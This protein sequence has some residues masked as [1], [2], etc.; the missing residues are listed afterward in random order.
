MVKWVVLAILLLPLAEIGVFILVAA[1][2]GWLWAFTLLLATTLA[3]VL[4]LRWAGRGR[5]ARFRVAVADGDVTAFE[6]S[7]GGFL[8]VLAGLLLLLPGFITDLI[9]ALLLIGPVQRRCAAA[10]RRAV[11]G[12]GNRRDHVVDLTPGEWTQVPDREL[13]QRRGPDRPG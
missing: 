8:T 10:F 2:L 12:G 1:L 7:T 11:V 3:G 13:D 5:L 6:A 9:G 4:A